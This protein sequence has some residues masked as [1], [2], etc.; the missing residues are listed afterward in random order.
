MCAWVCACVSVYV[1]GCVCVRAY[2]RVCVYVRVRVC[3]CVRACTCVCVRACV[4][5]LVCEPGILHKHFKH[6]SNT[7]S[8]TFC[9]GTFL[10]KHH[11]RC[12]VNQPERVCRRF[13]RQQHKELIRCVVQ[14]ITFVFLKIGKKREKNKKINTCLFLKSH[15]DQP[16]S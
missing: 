6:I 1:R 3:V 15:D 14:G 2:V 12:K 7:I 10:T 16:R 13:N 4:C 11:K 5:V 9:H 8:H